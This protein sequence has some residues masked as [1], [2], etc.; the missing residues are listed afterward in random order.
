M[1][2]RAREG[3]WVRGCVGAWVLVWVG[4]GVGVDASEDEGRGESELWADHLL[5]CCFVH[6]HHP[7]VDRQRHHARRDLDL[8]V[9]MLECVGMSDFG[10]SERQDHAL[11]LGSERL[12]RSSGERRA[13]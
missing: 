1:G 6:L 10:T 4:A 12:R 5:E 11:P 2:L 13:A 7:V 3:A 8:G 9:R